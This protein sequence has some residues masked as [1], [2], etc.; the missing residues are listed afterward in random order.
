MSPAID[1]A[2]SFSDDLLCSA[3]C[4]CKMSK[5]HPLYKDAML[6][7]SYFI[8]QNSGAKNIF[9]CKSFNWQEKIREDEQ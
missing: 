1:Q 8:D 5:H 4:P 9:E 6:N 7:S 2:F 3:K